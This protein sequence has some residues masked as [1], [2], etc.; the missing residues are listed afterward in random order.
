MVKGEPKLLRLMAQ[1]AEDLAVISALMQDAVV[2]LGDITYL[3]S[4]R[5]FALVG[6]RFDWLSAEGRKLERR[7]SGMHF[8]NV[9]TVSR[10][11][12]DPSRA[13]DMLNLLGILF[14]ETQAPAGRVTFTF[15]GGGTIRL[16]VE[17][18]EAQMRDLGMRWKT[19]RKPGHVNDE[20]R[21][22]DTN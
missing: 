8:D 11:G 3:P 1:D 5:R 13:D 14:E 2:R 18:V 21:A 22:K 17:C 19:R 12:L 15:S 9:L 16:E 7:Q 4:Q 10:L 20:S 6:S